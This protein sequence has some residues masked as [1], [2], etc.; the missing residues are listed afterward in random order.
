V[1]ELLHLR[2]GPMIALV[3]LVALGL[4]LLA[5]SLFVL[6]RLGWLRPAKT[7]SEQ[8]L[9]TDFGYFV[10]SP[11]TE[12]AARIVTT[13][14]IAGGGIALGRHVGPELLSGFGPVVRQPH[15]LVIAEMFVL[16]DFTY[17]WA[18][19]LAHTVPALWRLHAVH[20]STPH[21]RWT[22][23]MRA[24]PGEI[25]VHILPLVPLF[26]LGFPVD[27]LLPLGPFIMLYGFLIHSG[28][29]VSLRRV[30]F[31]VN[32]PVF[33]GW[34]HALDIRDG[35]KNYAGFFPLW[36]FVFGTYSLPEQHP[37]EVGIDDLDMPDTC[38]GQLEYPLRR[39]P[40]RVSEVDYPL[41]G[42]PAASSPEN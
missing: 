9:R 29:N 2:L 34:H 10:L 26:F 6:R 36:D 22:S 38:L 27:G 13:M 16:S 14:I 5:L 32:T 39:R 33:H 30:S 18:H 21:L 1:Q 40:A 42:I 20:H 4:P 25:Y 31:F 24:H 15:W 28:A 12:A 11:L 8:S 19:R 23:A 3:Q 41:S 7:P 17:Y 37:T 35:T